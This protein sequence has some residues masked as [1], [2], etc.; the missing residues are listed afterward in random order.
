[1]NRVPSRQSLLAGINIHRTC[2]KRDALRVDSAISLDHEQLVWAVRYAMNR[3]KSA[4]GW[5]PKSLSRK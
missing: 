3:R 1:M 2:R 4:V 5:F